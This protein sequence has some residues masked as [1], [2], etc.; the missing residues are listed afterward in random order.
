[1]LLFDISIKT[2]S[3]QEPY[4]SLTTEMLVFS[5]LGKLKSGW[6]GFRLFYSVSLSSVIYFCY[7]YALHF[8]SNTKLYRCYRYNNTNSVC[9]SEATC[10]EVVLG[11]FFGGKKHHHPPLTKNTPT[12]LFYFMLTKTNNEVG[13]TPTAP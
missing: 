4:Y 9:I 6:D 5:I 12:N 11:Y 7:F 2:P 1:M 8:R 10:T 3:S 13:G